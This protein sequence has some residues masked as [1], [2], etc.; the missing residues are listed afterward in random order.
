[1]PPLGVIVTLPL[2][3]PKQLTLFMPDAVN[4]N[5]EAGCAIVTII[6]VLHVF[7]SLQITV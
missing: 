2:L 5:A 4:T 3:P 7:A 6:C 1:V